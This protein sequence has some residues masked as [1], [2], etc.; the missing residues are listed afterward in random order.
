MPKGRR[1]E[2]RPADVIG[3]R[4]LP[5]PCPILSSRGHR[6]CMPSVSRRLNAHDHAPSGSGPL[7]RAFHP[8]ILDQDPLRHVA[9]V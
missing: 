9:D 7:L 3:K 2:K 1:G 4:P 5:K 8:R 6:H